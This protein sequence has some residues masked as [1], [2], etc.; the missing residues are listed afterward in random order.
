MKQVLILL[1]FIVCFSSI[2]AKSGLRYQSKLLSR[3]QNTLKR[4]NRSKAKLPNVHEYAY[5]QKRDDLLDKSKQSPL[6][7]GYTRKDHRIFDQG[8]V[9]PSKKY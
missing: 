7:D 3:V 6:D 1:L 9:H 8:Y 2:E 5:P 4:L